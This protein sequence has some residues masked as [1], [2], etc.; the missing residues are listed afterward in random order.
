MN[1]NDFRKEYLCEWVISDEYKKAYELWIWYEYNCEMYDRVVCSGRLDSYGFIRPTSAIENRA[2]G[3]NANKMKNKILDEAEKYNK[4]NNKE[5]PDDDWNS[6]K[7][8][9]QRLT[10]E[11]IQRE[12]KRIYES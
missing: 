4:T 1:Q 7:K 11:G 9:V 5:I 2:I 3:I 12:Y 10:W 6:A 8:E